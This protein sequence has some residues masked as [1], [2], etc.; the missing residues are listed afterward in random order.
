MLSRGHVETAAVEQS[1]FR[2]DCNCNL[3]L[4]E[5]FF[6]QVTRALCSTDELNWSVEPL[7]VPLE[8]LLV[9]GLM[10][11]ALASMMETFCPPSSPDLAQMNNLTFVQLFL[12]DALALPYTITTNSLI[13]NVLDKCLK[14]CQ[15]CI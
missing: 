6:F 5:S 10:D 9:S 12:R 2:N 3:S 14:M 15:I 1:R 11:L 8:L 7:Q 13:L 4:L